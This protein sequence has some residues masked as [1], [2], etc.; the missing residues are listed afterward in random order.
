VA[1]GQLGLTD[2]AQ[3]IFFSQIHEK[4]VYNYFQKPN[5]TRNMLKLF[6]KTMEFPLYLYFRLTAFYKY[7]GDGGAGGGFL[8][9][10]NFQ[11]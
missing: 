5:S 10:G 9:F 11:K 6:H 7:Y 4:Q 1:G 3:P 8:L 2:G